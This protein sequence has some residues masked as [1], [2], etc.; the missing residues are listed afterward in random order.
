MKRLCLCFTFCLISAIGQAEDF[1]S[2]RLH[3]WHQWRGP[4]A[5]GTA[6]H[7]AP[8][9]SW[10]RQTNIKW[11]VP[12]AG[13]G[14]ATPI[15]WGDQIFLVSAQVTSRQV[16]RLDPPAQEPPGGYMTRRP[17]NFYQ[18]RIDCLDRE[19]GRI[20]WQQIA[21]EDLPHEGRHGT[22]TY[23]SASPTT[24]GQRLFVSFGSRGLFCYD[25]D[26]NLLWKRDLGNMITRRG[27]GEGTSPVIHDDALIVNWDHEGESF[28]VVLD[29]ATGQTRWR[30]ERDEVTSWVTPRVVSYQDRQQLIVPATR[31]ITS[32]DL[33][34]GEIVWECGGLTTNVIPMPVIHE[35][36]VICMSG[37]GGNAAVAVRLDSQ[38]DVTNDRQQV[39]WRLTRDT[40]YVPS[41]ILY[42]DLLYFTKSNSAILTSVDPATGKTLAGNVRMP[43]LQNMYA[44]PVAANGR[45]YFTSREGTTLVVENKATLEVLAT[46]RLDQP[47]DASP[48]IVGDQLFLRTHDHLI[49]IAEP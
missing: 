41:P 24:D 20:V 17:T 14:H 32:Y 1:S 21:C 30:A 48:A 45:I 40:P 5:D 4:L 27:W 38:G 42:G 31:R 25:L 2:Q 13:E 26:G 44:S 16:D 18:F 12:V 10:D 28:L 8:P 3:Q 11:Q 35:D 47:I 49:C 19:T 34:T 36:L 37:H 43:G 6:P 22:N 33:E 15:I 23:A 29:P 7:G 39:V 46:N 9:I